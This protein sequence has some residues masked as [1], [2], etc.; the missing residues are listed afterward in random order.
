M[1]QA[2]SITFLCV[3]SRISKG[4]TI[5]P[6]GNASILR[7]PPVSLSTRSAKN[8]RA[9]CVVDDGGTA[10]W[11]LR[12]RVCWASA[13]PPTTASVAARAAATAVPMYEPIFIARLLPCLSLGC[14]GLLRSTHEPAYSGR[15]RSATAA[16]A[17]VPGSA[18]DAVP[19][20]RGSARPAQGAGLGAD[21]LLGAAAAVVC[22]SR[23]NAYG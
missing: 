6:P 2:P 9:S 14:G 20:L 22:N 4:G 15:V 18:A 16:S 19:R 21:N 1:P 8:L 5:A 12:V 10:D 3:A 17:G 13:G 11:N 23:A 7:L